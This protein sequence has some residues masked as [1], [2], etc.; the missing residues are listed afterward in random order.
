MQLL[1][2]F[3][4]ETECQVRELSKVTQLLSIWCGAGAEFCPFSE[5]ELLPTM[6]GFT[7]GFRNGEEV[8][9]KSKR[10]AASYGALTMGQA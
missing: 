8:V 4:G 9:N 1:T 2:H 6:C 5:P 10:T 3:A 7:C